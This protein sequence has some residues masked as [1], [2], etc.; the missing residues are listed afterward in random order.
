MELRCIRFLSLLFTSMALGLTLAHIFQA[1]NKIYPSVAGEEAVQHIYVDWIMLGIF[2]AFAM[3]TTLDQT[4][5]VRKQRKTFFCT[6]IALLCLVGAQVLFWAFTYS[7]NQATGNWTVSPV[8]WQELRQQGE[9]LYVVGGVLN[10]AALASLNF[11]L[12]SPEA[13]GKSVRSKMASPIARASRDANAQF[14]QDVASFHASWFE[15]RL[16]Q[17]RKTTEENQR[18]LKANAA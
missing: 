9:F 3:L 18:R 15:V 8:N 13:S 6:L 10:L 2:V 7:A 14:L 1:S 4:I 5:L 12:I 11:S 16:K 17:F